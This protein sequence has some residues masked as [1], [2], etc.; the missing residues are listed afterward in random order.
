MYPILAIET[1]AQTPTL[2]VSAA[3]DVFKK[4]LFGQAVTAGAGILTVFK[5][6]C[7]DL[8]L[9][10][11]SIKTV[12]VDIGPGSFTGIRVG[13]AFAKGLCYGLNIGIVPIS[14][15]KCHAYHYG[16]K[17]DT[18]CVALDARQSELYF[19]AYK[20]QGKNENPLELEPPCLI[21]AENLQEKL[22]SFDGD[23][24]KLLTNIGGGGLNLSIDTVEI[25][26][27]AVEGILELA[28]IYLKNGGKPL[29]AIEAKPFYIKDFIVKT[30][31]VKG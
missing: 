8:S 1:S 27:P 7:D 21:T 20:H 16:A 30:K 3:P 6:L 15:L 23:E 2:A 9:T 17:G 29:S 19:A 14:S 11:Q 12:A 13:L 26:S 10:P 31:A 28:G 18:V 24:L 4:A 5:K 25:A 22:L